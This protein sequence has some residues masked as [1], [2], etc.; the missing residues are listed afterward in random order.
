MLRS[1]RVVRQ[2]VGGEVASVV[3]TT[4]TG[5]STKPQTVQTVLLPSTTTSSPSAN[6]LSLHSSESTNEKVFRNSSNI[7][8]IN[9]YLFIFLLVL[10][11]FP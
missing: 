9:Y 8:I 1:E 10:P 2:M 6:V 3:V 4:D 11:R 5:C 7:Y